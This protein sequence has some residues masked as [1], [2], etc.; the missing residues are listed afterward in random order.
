MVDHD[1]RNALVGMTLLP[2]IASAAATSP[3]FSQDGQS[4]NRSKSLVAFFTRTGN[5]RVVAN[6]IRRATSSDMVEIVPEQPYPDD[7]QQTVDQARRETEEGFEPALRDTVDAIGSYEIVYLGFP[8]WGMTT[9]P[10]VRSF[11]ST[12]TLAAKTPCALHH[13][14]RLRRRQQPFGARRSRT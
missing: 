4:A 9:P 2:L 3:A 12:H 11:L 5:T 7:Y 1:R 13:A 8:I 10:I 6:Q 14:W